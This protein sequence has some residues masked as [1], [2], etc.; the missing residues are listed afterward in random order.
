VGGGVGVLLFL[1]VDGVCRLLE[2]GGLLCGMKVT[3]HY[4]EN[5]YE[6]STR[7]KKDI[8]SSKDPLEDSISFFIVPPVR[9]ERVS[10]M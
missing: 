8:E 9:V 10:I 5:V 4:V 6:C 1:V 7:E 2:E 3:D